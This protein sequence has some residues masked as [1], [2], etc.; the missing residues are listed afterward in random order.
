MILNSIGKSTKSNFREESMF[1]GLLLFDQFPPPQCAYKQPVV[2][3][4]DFVVV[5]VTTLFSIG[6]KSN[7]FVFVFLFLHF[8]ILMDLFFAFI[9][10][11]ANVLFTLANQQML[12]RHKSSSKTFISLSFS[13]RATNVIYSVCKRFLYIKIKFH[14]NYI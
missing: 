2:K 7:K 10:C 1:F 4:D 3:F 14:F 5:V 12:Q 13:L 6:P 9:W 11:F 8:Y